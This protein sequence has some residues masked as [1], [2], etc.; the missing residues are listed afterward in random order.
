[1]KIN[2]KF[3]TPPQ[4][5]LACI[6]A[7]G[8]A[9]TFTSCSDGSSGG[10]D[11]DSGQVTATVPKIYATAENITDKITSL[12]AGTHTITVTGEVN[13]I[14][15]RN[16]SN[17][18]EIAAALI[19]LKKN[20]PDAKV[21]LDL[22]GTENLTEIPEHAFEGNSSYFTD[23]LVGVVLPNTVTSIGEDSFPRTGITEISIPASVKSIE[24]YVFGYCSNLASVKLS[25]GLES[26]GGWAFRAC[27]SL[28]S[29]VIPDSVTTLVFGTFE[30]CS[31]LTE[32]VIGSGVTEIPDTMFCG[33][34][35]LET[36][37]IPTTVTK[38]GAGAF[39]CAL[40]AAEKSFT[41]KYAGT[42]ED[43]NKIY[44]D[45]NASSIM[46][47]GAKNDALLKATIVCT[48]GKGTYEELKNNIGQ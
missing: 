11:D 14:L 32:V 26:I 16:G 20:C 33:W 3:I 29:I 25:E 27:Y 18:S 17:P 37:H 13:G 40:D 43:W 10:S 30:D 2:F 35:S 15:T 1:M 19:E 12:S 41:V 46:T 48:D 7:L 42:V 38:I 28:K 9:F 44:V 4:W 21:I 45:M 47:T 36:I 5:I 8:L 22:S 24:D 31:S 6:L 34:S 39:Q 23:N